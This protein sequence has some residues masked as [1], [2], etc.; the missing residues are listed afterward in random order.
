M[1]EEIEI[2]REKTRKL[3]LLF[4]V[5][6]TLVALGAAAGLSFVRT[7]IQEDWQNTARPKSESEIL[8]YESELRAVTDYIWVFLVG[9]VVIAVSSISIKFRGADKIRRKFEKF[10]EKTPGASL[11]RLEQTW[12]HGY[13]FKFGRMDNEFII[14]S[15]GM[16]TQI[17][18]LQNAVMVYTAGVDIQ[19]FVAAR[20]ILYIEYAGEKRKQLE[21]P[22]GDKTLNKILGYFWLHYPHIIA[23]WADYGVSCAKLMKAKNWTAMREFARKQR[24]NPQSVQGGID[25][26]AI[27]DSAFGNKKK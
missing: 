25:L 13:D 10:C 5:V 11:E 17:A 20:R 7:R 9:G 4:F 16:H 15:N 12:Q 26:N 6:M 3:M 2:I 14:I 22:G 19:S 18:P 27:F 24:E 1:F 23:G 8:E 21:I